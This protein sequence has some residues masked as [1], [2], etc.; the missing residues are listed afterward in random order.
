MKII[1]IVY[2]SETCEAETIFTKDYFKMLD[3]IQM[4]CL[5]DAIYDLEL[6]RQDL[7]DEM[8]PKSEVKNDNNE[9]N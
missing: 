4:D 6:I 5:N 8:Y 9:L 3:T 1:E 2:N 7:H